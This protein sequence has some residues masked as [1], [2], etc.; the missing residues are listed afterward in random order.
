ML[1]KKLSLL[2]GLTPLFIVSC[3]RLPSSQ[4]PNATANL[5]QGALPKY[6]ELTKQPWYP[7][8]YHATLQLGMQHPVIGTI[9]HRLQLLGD[10]K[11]STTDNTLFDW[12]LEQAV[13][14]YQWRHGLD[15]NGKIN[16]RT[17]KA[18]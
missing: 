9:R 13:K 11:S 16:K 2:I 8:H 7:L 12:S 18:L 15:P 1:S 6:A 17:L 10:L 14:H 5:I 4:H 3:S